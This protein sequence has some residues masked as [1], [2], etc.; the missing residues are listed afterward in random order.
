MF[1]ENGYFGTSVRAIAASAGVDAALVI[2]YFGSKERLFL[3]TVQLPSFLEQALRGPLE[4]MGER[5]VAAVFTGD[6]EARLSVF[7][8]LTRASGSDSVREKM[9][10]TGDRTFFAPLVGRLEGPDARLRARLIGAQING[11]LSVLAQGQDEEL[12]ESNR[13]ALIVTYGRAVQ[14]L[15]DPPT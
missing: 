14:A 12:S 11:L 4:G 3:E 9:R 2:R 10:E 5:I 6:V 7:D 1:T 15:V 8:A 13:D